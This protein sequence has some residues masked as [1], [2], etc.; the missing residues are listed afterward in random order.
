MS[1]AERLAYPRVKVGQPPTTSNP[2]VLAFARSR[3]G[4]TTEMIPG[5]AMISQHLPAR[6]T[7]TLLA[8]IAAMSIGHAAQESAPTAASPPST[9][10][11][12]IAVA[13]VIV[14]DLQK[15]QQFYEDM[16]GM[17]EVAR[18]SAAGVYDEPLLGFAESDASNGARLALFQPKAEARLK[19]PEAPQVLIYTP[20]FEKVVKRIEDAKQPIRRLSA[21]QSG[22]FKI[23]IARDPSGN[24]V[25]LFAREGKPSAVGGSKLIVDNRAKAEAFYADVFGVKPLQRYQT[26]GYDEV[27]MAF[28]DGPWLA[29]FEPKTEAALPK[30]RFALVAIYTQDFDDVL[31]KIKEHGLGFRDVKTSSSQRR[32]II[33]QDPAGNAIEI[34]SQ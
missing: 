20:D 31:T 11:H 28:G 14:D 30:S 34:I 27:L 32:I 33:A 26:A 24:A 15:T 22:T 6:A 21:D 2:G 8:A 1:L 10:R 4:R 29:L 13:K 5:D 25:E 19:K 23:A 17:K 18:Y 3:D 12:T 16:F 7:A 9:S